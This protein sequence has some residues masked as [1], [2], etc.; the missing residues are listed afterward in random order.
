[1]IT[2]LIPT[3]EEK[4]NISILINNI[5]ELKISHP[6]TFFFI[7]D[8]SNDGSKNI[9]KKISSD[10]NNVNYFIRKNKKKDLT[11]SLLEGLEKVTSEYV[12]ILDCDLQHELEK[13][14]NMIDLIMNQKYDLV[15][16]KRDLKNIKSKTR[17]FFTIIGT[18][19]SYLAGIEKIEDPLSGFFIIKTNLFKSLSYKINNSGFKILISIIFYLNNNK[20]IC[21]V[22]IKF[23]N[24]KF[25]SSKF[26][27]KIIYLFII[28]IFF[29]RFQK[30][31][32][33]D[34]Y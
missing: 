34:K 26:S 25:G 11:K 6:Y 7:D 21:E 29:L 1:M 9:F 14:P 12:F 8:N 20:N 4:D 17:R 2:F 5:N 28:Q 32:N 19:F 13:I 30:I 22:P 10:N 33:N 27:L 23:K 31:K 18:K 15:I 24:R 3:F 16:G